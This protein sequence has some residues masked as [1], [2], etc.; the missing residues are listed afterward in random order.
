MGNRS[1]DT[2]SCDFVKTV[3][4]IAVVLYHSCLFWTGDWFVEEPVHPSRVLGLTAEYLNS[5]HIYGFTLVS[6]YLL[7]YL[8][9]EKGRYDRYW[10]FVTNKAVPY[11][12]V[13][14]VWVIP[15]SVWFSGYGLGEVLTRYILGTAPA[16][17]WFLLMLFLV[18]V[19]A[20]PLS[21]AFDRNGLLGALIA[22]GA[23]G[24][25]IL[26]GMV[27]PNYF[28]VWTA[29]RY[30]IFFWMGYELRR[31]GTDALD[32]IPA[33]LWIGAHVLLFVGARYVSGLEG[34]VYTAIYLL[35]ELC[36]HGVGAMMAFFV[37]RKLAARIPWQGSR[38][39]RLLSRNSMV[40]YLLHQQM[41]YIILALLNGVVGPYVN[42]AANFL[43][44]LALPVLLGTLLRRYRITRFLIGEK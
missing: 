3:L 11:V 37:L 20:W 43:V 2:K 10:P 16:Q 35:L 18:F 14:A 44:A 6:G 15:V 33:V 19:A 40:I 34:T 24:V 25:G 29:C 30:L 17:L 31:K 32:K 8:K 5:F 36:L 28:S 1:T 26:G 21:G 41:I 39:F 42:A 27:L 23:Y 7:C 4:M 38:L 13:A 22:L 12:F 9:R